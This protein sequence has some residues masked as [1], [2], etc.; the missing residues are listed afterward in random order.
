MY[1]SP[2]LDHLRA[3]IAGFLAPDISVLMGVSGDDSVSA[4]CLSDHVCRD[5]GCLLSQQKQLYHNLIPQSIYIVAG[6]HHLSPAT[7]R[8]RSVGAWDLP[9]LIVV[10]PQTAPVL[11]RTWGSAWAV[12]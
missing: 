12:L 1:R 4:Y 11:V 5:A 7:D 3:R 8:T 10:G 6:G 9:R 2:A